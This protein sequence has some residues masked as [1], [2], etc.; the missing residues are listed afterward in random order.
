MEKSPPAP[1]FC[2]FCESVRIKKASTFEKQL[3]GYDCSLDIYLCRNCFMVFGV[4]YPKRPIEE[5]HTISIGKDEKIIRAFIEREALDFTPNKD[6][7]WID[8]VFRIIEGHLDGIINSR[9][10]FIKSYGNS[11]ILLRELKL[12]YSTGKMNR[13]YTINLCTC[14]KLEHT[15]ILTWI[16]DI[17]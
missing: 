2:P 1:K 3:T 4:D 12:P 17:D 8:D 14:G 15:A 16:V 6:Q 11:G 7:E 13:D 5:K 10:I 9:Y